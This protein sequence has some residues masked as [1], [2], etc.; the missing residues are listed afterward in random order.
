VFP[1]SGPPIENGCVTILGERI[2]SVGPAT[3]KVAGTLRVPSASSADEVAIV[4]GFVN[5]HTHLEFSDLPAPLGAP[6]MSMGD[7]V[8]RVIAHRRATTSPAWPGI[9][10]GLREGL[11]AGTTALGEIA[12]S[13]WREQATAS[14]DVLPEVVMFH[15]SLA[16]TADRV[17]G[18]IAAAEQ[19]LNAKTVD[20]RIRPALSPHAP[21]TVPPRLLNVLVDLA[22]RQG[23]PLAMHLGESPEELDLLASGSGPLRALLESAGAWDAAASARHSRILDYLEALAQAPRALAIHGNYL[24]T[25]DLAF[26]AARAATMAVVYCPRTHAYFEH[27]P[28]PL[29]QMLRLGVRVALGTDSRA[30]NPDLSMLAEMRFVVERHAEVSPAIALELATLAGAR[31]LGLEAQMGTLEPGKLANLAIIQLGEN[32]SR[33]PHTGLFHPGSHVVQ[34]YVRGRPAEVDAERPPGK[35]G[36]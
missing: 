9:R 21:Y 30:S 12:T 14:G 27:P 35:A 28:Y 34:A 4:P 16:P 1:V 25:E 31:A 11:L 36:G 20:P 6:G 22:G 2:V 18:A 26:L 10:R 32:A 13:D 17:V 29:A 24:G 33:D 15:E 7:W 5:A 3:P 23:V 8:A 19:F